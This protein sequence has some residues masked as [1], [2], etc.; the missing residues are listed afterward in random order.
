MPK[1]V[2]LKVIHPAVYVVLCICQCHFGVTAAHKFTHTHT[3]NN[4]YNLQYRGSAV[5]DNH[6]LAPGFLE[7]LEM[8]R[9]VIEKGCI[10][11]TA[12]VHPLL[13]VKGDSKSKKKAAGRPK[14]SK[15]KERDSPF[16]SKPFKG[17]RVFPLEGGAAKGKVQA[18]PGQLT[19]GKDPK[20]CKAPLDA[21][22]SAA[23]NFPPPYFLTKADG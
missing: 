1:G 7:M 15:G 14:G 4:P 18:E 9:S 6:G 11:V 12:E 8:H 19:A 10:S 3:L 22:F 13:G 20:D 2:E 5:G 23:P 17:E 21:C 16:K